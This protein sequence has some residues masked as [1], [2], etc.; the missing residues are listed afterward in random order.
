MSSNRTS[1]ERI[2]DTAADIA[3]ESG[4]PNLTIGNLADTLGMSKS[5]IFRYFG[6]RDNLVSAVV[7]EVN[8]RFKSAVVV[9]TLAADDGICRL[10]TAYSR[11]IDWMRTS[12][13]SGCASE[14]ATISLQQVEGSAR[15]SV[16]KSRGLWL[17]AI[18]SAA[19]RAGAA[20]PQVFAW[21]LYG[22]VLAYANLRPALGDAI[23]TA[24][25]LEAYST[26]KRSQ[27]RE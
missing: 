5:G 16:L 25:S 26:L 18:E 17:N 12:G 1:R 7:D 15:E 22:L 19:E 13:V 24:Q 2:V 9:P 3:C 8:G 27:I 11:W 23:A 21:S 14:A 10:D 20:S 6:S 4:I